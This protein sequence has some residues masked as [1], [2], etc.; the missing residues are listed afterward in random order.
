MKAV[1][2]VLQ[3]FAVV[4]LSTKTPTTT[5]K[6]AIETRIT[7]KLQNLILNCLQGLFPVPTAHQHQQD[8]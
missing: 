2:K 6:N 7:Q 4:D 8:Y 3:T 5:P 1:A